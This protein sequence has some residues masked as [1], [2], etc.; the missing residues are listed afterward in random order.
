MYQNQVVRQF[1][2]QLVPPLPA[3]ILLSLHHRG[4]WPMQAEIFNSFRHFFSV[5]IKLSVKKWPE[6]TL[7][8]SHS[9]LIGD[10]L[11]VYLPV[12]LFQI[13]SS[14]CRHR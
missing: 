4:T 11:P 9:P 5:L 13:C 3:S 1:E 7:F 2:E 10:P 12:D 6:V 14:S 8:L